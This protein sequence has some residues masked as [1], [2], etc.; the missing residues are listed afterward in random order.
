MDTLRQ[1]TQSR[2]L[3]PMTKQGSPEGPR[4]G[5]P[6]K[7]TIALPTTVRV[8]MPDQESYDRLQARI[9]LAPW[10]GVPELLGELI[11]A[12]LDAQKEK[13]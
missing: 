4:K 6:A 3:T 10:G 9:K 1:L 13:K 7:S 11:K 12:G 5:G 2:I 8:R